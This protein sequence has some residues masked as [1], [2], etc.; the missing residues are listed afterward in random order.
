MCIR[1]SLGLVG[2]IVFLYKQFMQQLWLCNLGWDEPISGQLR[3]HWHS[4]CDK[5]C[6]ISK[7]IVPRSIRCKSEAS[8]VELRGFSDASET[9]YGCCVYVRVLYQ[10]SSASCHLLCSKSRVASY[11]RYHYLALNSALACCCLLYTSGFGPSSSPY[12]GTAADVI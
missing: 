2:P 11:E 5:L 1:D 6:L 10:D 4:L 9:G 12:S 7:I 3:L 8:I